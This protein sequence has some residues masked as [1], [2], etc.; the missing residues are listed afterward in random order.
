[1]NHCPISISNLWPPTSDVCGG[2]RSANLFQPIAPGDYSVRF[3]VQLSVVNAT[4]SIAVVPDRAGSLKG[5][6]A[7]VRGKLDC[8]HFEFLR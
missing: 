6:G 2:L 7:T 1:M 8:H 5:G 4:K 3:H